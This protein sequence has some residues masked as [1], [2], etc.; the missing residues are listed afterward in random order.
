MKKFIYTSFTFVLAISLHSQSYAQC[1][2]CP[3]G[4]TVITVPSSTNISLAAGTNYCLQGSGSYT[5]NLDLNGGALYIGSGVTY[6]PGNQNG[7]T[8]S[9]I[10]NCGTISRQQLLR[11]NVKTTARMWRMK[12]LIS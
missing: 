12:S 4:A 2:T 5:G 7:S 8:A 3:A 11:S 10:N 1:P 6:N 9:T